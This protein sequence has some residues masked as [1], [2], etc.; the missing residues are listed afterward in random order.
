MALHVLKTDGWSIRQRT[1]QTLRIK[2]LKIKSDA[3][4]NKKN[5]V[6]Q[7]L[8]TVRKIATVRD[9]NN[10]CQKYIQ[11]IEKKEI[12]Q[13]ASEVWLTWMKTKM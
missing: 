9:R 10:L 2:E 7:F 1:E 4:E 8:R 3:L 6:A 12:R 13:E 11:S 5:T